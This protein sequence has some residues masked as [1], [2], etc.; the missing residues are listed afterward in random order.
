MWV[1]EHAH[2]A[3]HAAAARETTVYA[4]RQPHLLLLLQLPLQASKLWQHPGLLV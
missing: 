4:C 2:A 3:L 1:S